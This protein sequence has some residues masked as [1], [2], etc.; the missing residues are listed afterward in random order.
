MMDYDLYAILANVRN[1]SGAEYISNPKGVPDDCNKYI[2]KDIEEW[3][4]DGHSH[5]YLTLRELVEWQSKHTKVA[6]KGLISPKEAKKLDEEGVLPSMWCQGTSD[7][8]WVWRK[9][10]REKKPLDPIINEMK[11]RL[12]DFGWLFTEEQINENMDKI[13]IVFWFDN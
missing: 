4:V 12:A 6:Q 10:Y 5:S 9:W 2:K 7:K 13:R 8:T 11:N 3:G 1:Y